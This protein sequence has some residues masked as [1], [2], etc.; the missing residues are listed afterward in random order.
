MILQ[1][2]SNNFDVMLNSYAIAEPLGLQIPIASIALDEYEKSVFL[3]EAQEELL[4]QLYKGYTPKGE[5]FDE[6]EESKRY[7]SNSIAESSITPTKET[8]TIYKAELPE[9]LWFI[10]YEEVLFNKELGCFSK[11]LPAKVEPVQQDK[12]HKILANPFKGPNKK[13]VL[14]VDNSNNEV[15]LISLYSIDSYNIKYLKK[16]T[17]IIL[18]NLPEDLNIRGLTKKTEPV[19]HPML[20]SMI[21]QA[22]VQ[23]AYIIKRNNFIQEQEQNANSK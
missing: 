11:L 23:K 18:I 2:L 5:G 15:E 21:L 20:H 9:D 22:A 8:S 17:P 13:R 12:L 7:L 16:P 10:T 1:E 6:T 14:R 3:T 19:A 4:Y